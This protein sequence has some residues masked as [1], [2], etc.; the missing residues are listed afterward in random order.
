MMNDRI[1]VVYTFKGAEKSF[2]INDDW[3][4]LD[5]FREIINE[6]GIVLKTAIQ[7]YEQA[8]YILLSTDIDDLFTVETDDKRAMSYRISRF[9]V[10]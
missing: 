5:V 8:L 3:S 7:T 1:R 10:R 9:S 4:F 2:Y 6:S